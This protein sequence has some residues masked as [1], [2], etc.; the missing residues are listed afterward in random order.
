MSQSF[1][2]FYQWY[3]DF[4]DRVGGYKPPFLENWFDKVESCHNEIRSLIGGRLVQRFY[5]SKAAQAKITK[6]QAEPF[7]KEVL[8]I[9]PRFHSDSGHPEDIFL[10][11]T[12]GVGSHNVVKTAKTVRQ[13]VEGYLK[14]NYGRAGCLPYMAKLDKTLSRLGEA[15]A[16]ARTND[17][18]LEVTLSTNP[19]GFALLGHYGADSDSCFRQGSDKTDH[20]Y[21]VGQTRNSFVITIGKKDARQR[22]RNVAR[23]FG[24]LSND[25][26]SLK[27]CN[28]YF[29][30]GF[31]E[32]DGLFALKS[33]SEEILKSKVDF[34]EGVVRIMDAGVS[35][36]QNPYANWA[37]VKEGYRVD[38]D[39]IKPDLENIRYIRCSNCSTTISIDKDGRP[40]DTC[41]DIDGKLCCYDCSCDAHTCDIS[42]KRTFLP[43]VKVMGP[44]GYMCEVH[45]EVAKTMHKC[46][47][48]DTLAS[49]LTT[50]NNEQVCSDCLEDFTRCDACNDPLHMSE[51]VEYA[52][53]DICKK[54]YNAGIIPV[55]ET[56]V[57]AIE[58]EP[59]GV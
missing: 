32:G 15:W 4:I 44:D 28:Y 23:C 9:Y 16:K 41:N 1:K 6:E 8:E 22:Y 31:D 27:L 35:I 14:D 21:V 2:E 25:G 13:F 56:V 11:P 10:A 12:M 52:G 26:N 51:S 39:Y 3:N 24:F 7:I 42:G 17:S 53:L 30:E 19:K 37:F 55:P 33:I 38:S 20:K 46:G 48:C 40:V 29:K 59:S 36:F 18:E 43:L 47:R 34:K 57:K 49:N 58:E 50:I 54:C 45:P 5:V